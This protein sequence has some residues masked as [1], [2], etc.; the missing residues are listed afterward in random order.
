MST[1]SK[2][3]NNMNLLRVLANTPLQW[4]LT[5]QEVPYKNTNK[6]VPR[7]V[8]TVV[9]EPGVEPVSMDFLPETRFTPDT[10]LAAFL[11]KH[12]P[13]NPVLKQWRD[14]RGEMPVELEPFALEQLG[15]AM[16]TGLRKLADSKQS[17]I[18]WNA[19][20][21]VHPDDRIKVWDTARDVLTEEFGTGAPVIRRALAMTLRDRVIRALDEASLESVTDRD[22][23]AEARTDAQTFALRMLSAG[24]EMTELEEWMW[25]WLGYVVKDAQLA[26]AAAA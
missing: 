10:M 19:L 5:V 21:H 11:A 2:V 22:G 8:L 12:D 20:H 9:R 4:S 16:H 6:T 25:S 13:K 3:E 14:S 1:S 15:S 17:V 18:T 7:Q 24:C 26:L 23:K